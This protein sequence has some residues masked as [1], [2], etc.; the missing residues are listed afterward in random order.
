MKP[1]VR[2]QDNALLQRALW[3]EGSMGSEVLAMFSID[4]GAS[5]RGMC[6]VQEFIEL[7]MYAHFQKG[8]HVIK[9]RWNKTAVNK[10]KRKIFKQMSMLQRQQNNPKGGRRTALIKIKTDYR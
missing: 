1:R 5:Y 8:L 7:V 4:V 2:S 3:V 6:A 9:S 10:E